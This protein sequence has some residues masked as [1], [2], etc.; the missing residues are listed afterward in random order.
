LAPLERALNDVI[1]GDIDRPE[2]LTLM[3]GVALRSA[4]AAR[5]AGMVCTTSLLS[6]TSRRALCTS[7]TGVSPVTVIVSSRPPTRISIG[8]VS[9]CEPD[10]S[11]SA[12]RTVTKPGSVAVSV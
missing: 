2:S 1:A 11:T 10:S 5:V 8:M 3:P 12:R 7:T 4:P 9:V 6:T